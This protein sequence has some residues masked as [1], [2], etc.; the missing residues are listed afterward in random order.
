MLRDPD[1]HANLTYDLTGPEALTMTEVARVLTETTGQPVKYHE[2]TVDEAYGSRR[3]WDAPQW[4]YDAWVS[5][6][7]AIALGQ[8]AAVT[9][10]VHSVTGSETPIIPTLPD[11]PQQLTHDINV[12]LTK[13][14]LVGGP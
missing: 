1:A 11:Q 9:R 4:L 3:R 2:E 13:P 6:Y 7:T 12:K 8:L 5:T 10:D 14:R